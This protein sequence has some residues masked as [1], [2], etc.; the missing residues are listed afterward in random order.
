MEDRQRRRGVLRLRGRG[1]ALASESKGEG[2]R[3]GEPAGGSWG[4]PTH[5]AADV[6]QAPAAAPVSPTARRKGVLRLRGRGCAASA[7]VSLC[8]HEAPPAADLGEIPPL[9]QSDTWDPHPSQSATVTTVES[10]SPDAAYA[11]CQGRD[12]VGQEA[13]D[14][15]MVPGADSCSD[16]V[17]IPEC[18]LGDESHVHGNG[19][20]ESRAVAQSETA[21]GGPLGGLPGGHSGNGAPRIGLDTSREHRVEQGSL[22]EKFDALSDDPSDDHDTPRDD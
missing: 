8:T 16:L 11:V 21:L 9:L 17:F 19:A 7:R 22:C 12:A 14:G 2:E 15:E 20:I 6:L 18:R 3:V 1:A 10:V 13:D 4:G 5:Q